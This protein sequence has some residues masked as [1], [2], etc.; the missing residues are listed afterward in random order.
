VA[1]WIE[2]KASGGR[3]R[4]EQAAF[5]DRCLEAGVADIVGGGQ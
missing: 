1:L 4:P 2:V 5:R 3:L